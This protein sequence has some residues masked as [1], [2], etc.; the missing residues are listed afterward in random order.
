MRTYDRAPIESHPSAPTPRYRLTGM[1]TAM[2]MAFLALL[3]FP[4]SVTASH[5]TH[6][7]DDEIEDY[8]F[9]FGM[10][11]FNMNVPAAGQVAAVL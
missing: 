1:Q 2:K 8:W 11:Q 6:E 7:D 4:A 3:I 10:N 9:P 5:Y